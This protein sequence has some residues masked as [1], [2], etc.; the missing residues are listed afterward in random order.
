MDRSSRC[1]RFP[2]GRAV[3]L[4]ELERDP[5]PVFARLREREPVSWLPALDMW[6]VVGYADVRDMLLDSRRL[7]TVSDRSTIYDT[8]G[9]HVLTSEG[10]V[11][12][13]YRQAAG[14]RFTPL[15]VRAHLE[16]AIHAAAAT[17]I[18]GFAS[19]GMIDLRPAFAARL[20]IQVMLML[21]GISAE[22]ETEMRRWYDSF[23]AAL[24]NFSGDPQ[25]REAARR[26]VA[27]FHALLDAPIATAR[28][29]GA[30]GSA[31]AADATGTTQRA[32]E[33]LIAHL[34]NAPQGLS[35]AEIKRNLSIIFFG[36]IS[37][38]E[39]LLLNSLWALFE[40]PASLERVRR[41][42][43]LVPQL[44]E[45]TMRWLS[46][47]QSA[48]RHVAE[49]FEWKGIEFAAHDTVNCMLGAA[50]RDPAIFADP[51]RFDLDRPNSRRHL[52]F[53][54]GTHACL[55]SHLAKA[56]ARIALEALF[57]GLAELE[58]DWALSEPPS[59][60]EFRQPRRLTVR[61][62]PA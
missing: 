15:A 34:A 3:S 23:E 55:G 43:T 53:A 4:G 18:E 30:G 6:Y 33:S 45:E 60:Y 21:C 37:T 5:Y 14:A 16:A 44:L 59:G 9:E 39:A 29:A 36:G 58:I 19:R 49:P 8:F 22:A 28:K 7:T 26:S 48:T 17:L 27:E 57:G 42:L 52:G 40:N 47:V 50:N 51:D 11:H 56:E 61:W 10:T 54:T 12:E 13:R 2:L 1:E 38:V 20:P 62:R 31:N 24:A 41:D 25:V 46:P 35:D 32:G